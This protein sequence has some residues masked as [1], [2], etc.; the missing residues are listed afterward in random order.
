MRL[1]VIT[2]PLFLQHRHILAH[3]EN[4]GRL[5]TL[6]QQ[7]QAQPY[8]GSLARVPL[9]H[10]NGD[11]L[12]LVHDR[13]Y[14]HALQSL[15]HSTM[16][17]QDTYAG[18][19]SFTVAAV[20]TGSILNAVDL[21]MNDELDCVFVLTRPPGHHASRNQA[22]G[23]CLLNHAAVASKFIGQKY[24]QPVAILDWDAH[25]GNGTQSIFY[26][27][28]E[29]LYVSSHQY[30]FYPGSGDPLQ[31]GQDSGYGYNLN[32]P[33]PRGLPAQQFVALYQHLIIPTI[34]QFRPK[35]LIVSAGF[36]AHMDDPLAQLSLRASDFALLAALV[37]NMRMNNNGLKTIYILEGGYDT[38]A[39]AASVQAVIEVL[40]QPMDDI[41]T[42]LKRCALSA[43]ESSFAANL[44]RVYPSEINVKW[45]FDSFL[46][47]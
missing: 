7:L 5:Q 47:G 31:L 46:R 30:P 36:D 8:F 27:D 23:F 9:R 22:M 39:L 37:E 13:A 38:A 4:P 21:L 40:I 24:Q 20:A 16:L 19:S 28:P 1:G 25:H 45:R 32:F 42:L 17:D 15:A 18:A 6:T 34:E 12:E 29:V 2:D 14:L 33:L 44:V 3:P 43:K 26:R 35:I 41:K 11:E 10:A